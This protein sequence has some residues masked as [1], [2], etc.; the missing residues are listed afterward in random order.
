MNSTKPHYI[1]TPEE[2]AAARAQDPRLT[3][4]HKGRPFGTKIKKQ[5]AIAGGK[6]QGNA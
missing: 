1:P 4:K 2:L 5:P 6:G 3:R